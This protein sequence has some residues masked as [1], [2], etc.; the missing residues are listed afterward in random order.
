MVVNKYV[1]ASET[2]EKFTQAIDNKNFEIVNGKLKVNKGTLAERVVTRKMSNEKVAIIDR[3]ANYILNAFSKDFRAAKTTIQDNAFRFTARHE[4]KSPHVYLYKHILGERIQKRMPGDMQALKD[5]V[6]QDVKAIPLNI[7]EEMVNEIKA[8]KGTAKAKRNEPKI[9]ANVKQKAATQQLYYGVLNS[10]KKANPAT[11]DDDAGAIS[12]EK[13][14]II[15]TR[16]ERKVQEKKDKALAKENAKGRKA[17]IT[18]TMRANVE[19]K[20]IFKA[21]KE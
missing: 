18:E 20:K 5:E 9:L 8:K 11:I 4:S 2:Y 10:P 16:Q 13:E 12:K 7:A 1:G 15:A 21:A 14:A 19:A 17:K 3:I 6:R